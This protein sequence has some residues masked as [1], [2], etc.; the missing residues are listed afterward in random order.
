MRLW[1]AL[2]ARDMPTRSDS[3]QRRTSSWVRRLITAGV[4]V[5]LPGY[6]ANG[7]GRGSNSAELETVGMVLLAIGVLL[8]LVGVVAWLTQRFAG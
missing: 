5:G 4:V 1:D 6:L 2:T 7:A 3:E 8:V